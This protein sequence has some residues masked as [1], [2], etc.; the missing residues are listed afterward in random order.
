MLVAS[1]SSS[2]ANGET[3]IRICLDPRDLNVA[4]KREHFPMPTIEEIATRLNGAK[5]FSVFD[6]SNGFWQVEHDEESS[7]LT[8]FNTPFGRYLWKGMPFGITSAPEVW[9]RKMRENIGGLKGV[10]VIADDFV[11]VGYGD[12]PAEWQEDHNKNVVAFLDRCRERNLKLNKNK[13]RLRQ[14]EVLFIGHILTPEG[15]KPDLCKVE[16]IVKMPDPTDVQSLRRFLGMVN[17][18]A[19]FLPRLSDETEPLR[20][21]T[22][23]DSEWCWLPAHADAV[24]HVKEMIVTAPVLAY[25][26]VSKPVVI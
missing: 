17:Y 23:K 3:K 10:E 5:L 25:Y 26:D 22:E 20:K 1:K 4:I 14:Q 7:L 24:A 19:K 13:A 11:V 15:L 8:T 6:A 2:G 21:L 18:L 12:T 16:A 9:Q